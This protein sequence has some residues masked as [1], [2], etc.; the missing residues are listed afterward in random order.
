MAHDLF[1]SHSSRDKKMARAVCDILEAKGL[2]CWI[3]P[4]DIRPGQEWP[5]AIVNAVSSSK[6]MI[7][8]F[9]KNADQSVD[10]TKETLLAI[11]QDVDIFPIKVEESLPSGVMKYYLADRE[12]IDAV[13]KP[14]EE[15][16]KPLLK[17]IEAIRS[18]ESEQSITT[19]SKTEKE[20]PAEKVLIKGTNKPGS[21]LIN[22]LRNKLI[23]VGVLLATV[24]AAFIFVLADPG[25]WF[26]EEQ[27]GPLAKKAYAGGFQS[28]VLLDNGE[29]YAFGGNHNGCLGT[30]STEIHDEPAL[31]EGLTGIADISTNGNHT[32]ILLE[33]GTVY[34]CGA[35]YFGQ[36]G[37]GNTEDQHS[38]VLIEELSGAT[39]VAAGTNHSLVLH[40]NG[41]LYS[42]GRGQAGQL[43]TELTGFVEYR[44]RPEKVENLP[45]IVAIA[46]GDSF[47]LAI[48]AEGAVYSFGIN[49]FGQ[50]GHDGFEQ[51]STPTK[52]EGIDKVEAIAAGAYHSLIL[53]ESGEVYSFGN[54]RKGQLGHGAAQSAHR[55]RRIAH[56][57]DITA[58]SAGR[59]HSLVL[60]SSGIVYSFGSGANGML[61]QGSRDDQFNPV[62]IEGIAPVTSIA[63]GWQHSL[64]VDEKAQVLSFGRNEFGQLGLGQIPWSDI[65]EHLS[66]FDEGRAN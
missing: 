9:T 56:L 6:A 36:L 64:L 5:V 27:S 53:N 42:F 1:I 46:A 29:V 32:L 20:I 7:L 50:L 15:V 35:N 61:G 30:G 41:D 44:T 31:I 19:D 18:I 52:I 14:L 62:M 51:T 2:K 24:I 57:S 33:N 55:P 34:T 16:L 49:K 4:R 43:G 58:I 17:K 60:D 22:K 23:P 10:V 11:N 13:D 54:G 39:A 12:W 45:P 66:L 26:T 3:A 63:A 40:E 65:P 21:Y 28:F 48:S 25:G 38:P 8:I 37:I 47:S 59:E